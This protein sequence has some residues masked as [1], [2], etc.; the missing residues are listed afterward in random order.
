VQTRGVVVRVVW[1]V[2]SCGLIF[3]FRAFMVVVVFVAVVAVVAVFAVGGGGVLGFLREVW[4]SS[5]IV[6]R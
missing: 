4:Q 3:V 2:W 1:W 5:A 6:R